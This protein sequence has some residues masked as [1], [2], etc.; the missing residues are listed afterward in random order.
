VSILARFRGVVN[1]FASGGA[2]GYFSRGIG[3]A[4]VYKWAFPSDAV[5]TTTAAPNNFAFQHNS[6]FANPAVAGYLARGTEGTF[7]EIYKWAFPSDAVST[8]TSSPETLDP[9]GAGFAN[10]AVAG[11]LARGTNRSTV[12]KW[13]FP[14]DAVSTTTSAPNVME[15]NAGFANP[16]VAG[17]LTRGTGGTTTVYKWALPSDAVSTTTSSNIQLRLGNS[18]FAN[19]AVAGYFS[20]G[21]TLLRVRKWSFPSDAMSATT[22]FPA[23]G[24]YHAGFANPAVA[25]YF[26]RG[27]TGF[28][29]ETGTTTVYKWAF[30]SDAV[31]TTTSSPASMSFHAGFASA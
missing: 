4:T 18:G 19:P 2:A 10:P 20:E 31:S 8:T 26:S 17:Y 30:P 12:Y 25:G 5:S 3:T 22:S 23:G 16:A 6:G 9:P 11:Y 27:A 15:Y 13:A 7:R 14:S 29:F 1:S 21:D 28:T 24:R